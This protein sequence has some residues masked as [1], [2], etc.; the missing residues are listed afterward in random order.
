MGRGDRFRKWAE[1]IGPLVYKVIDQLLK[2]C[3]VEEQ[4]Y[5]ACMSILKFADKYTPE[6]LEK[7]CAKALSV[8]TVPRYKD[9]KLILEHYQGEPDQEASFEVNG[10]LL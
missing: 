3:K 1:S 10:S 4:G 6:R 8:I 2:S 5:N 7:T 9:I